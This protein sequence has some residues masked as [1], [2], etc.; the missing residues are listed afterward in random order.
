M[1][2]MPVTTVVKMI[3]A[4][5]ILIS[6]RNPSLSGLNFVPSNAKSLPKR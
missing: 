4:T 1:P 3:G 2:A 6:F 5:I